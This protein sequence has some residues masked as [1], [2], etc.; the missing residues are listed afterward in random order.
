M[1]IVKTLYGAATGGTHVPEGCWASA[2]FTLAA[3]GPLMRLRDKI[4]CFPNLASF[5]I[6]F[7]SQVTV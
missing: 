3:Q 6:N 2:K 1:C 5:K 7:A 4:L